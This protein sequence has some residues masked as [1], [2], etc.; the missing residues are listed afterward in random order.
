MKHKFT[1]FMFVFLTGF[2]ANQLHAQS[3]IIKTKAG[4]ENYKQ[5]SSL[6]SISFSNDNLQLNFAGGSVDS[7]SLS[8]VGKLYFNPVL[9]DTRNSL[10]N[11]EEQLLIYPNPVQDIL[12]LQN[13]PE[14]NFTVLIYRMD[15]VLAYS[16]PVLAGNKSIDVSHLASGLY[17]L[18]VNN[19]TC[20]FIKL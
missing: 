8:T 13:A 17:V 7:Y 18:K 9:T 6:K 11:T 15:V 16:M 5:L 14:G 1:L 3:L 12:Y 4:T 10:T 20:K 19:Q 2:G